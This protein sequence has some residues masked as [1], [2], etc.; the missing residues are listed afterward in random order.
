MAKLD[1]LKSS[2]FWGF[3]PVRNFLMPIFCFFSVEAGG[4]AGLASTGHKG[5][6]PVM[7]VDVFCHVPQYGG[8]LFSSNWKSFAFSLFPSLRKW[9]RFRASMALKGIKVIEMSGLAPAP[10]C[11]MILADFGASVIRIDRARALMDV[12]RLGRGKRSI[13]LNLK[14]PQGRAV[15]HQ[16]CRRADVLIDP[17]RRGVMEKLGLGP[18]VLL[19]EN[20]KL[21]YA[22]LTGFGQNGPLADRAGHDI[23][24]LA[25]SGVLSML[26]RSNESPLPPVN[27]L[28]D[29]AGGGLICALGIVMALFHRTRSNQGQVIDTSMVEGAAYVSSWLYKSQDLFVW[30][31]PRG[32]NAL[33]GGAYFYQTYE[34]KDSKY[35]AVGALEP[36]FFHEF[37][38]KLGLSPSEFEH[39]SKWEENKEHIA[40]I[41]R[42]KTQEEWEKIFHESDACVTP[43][44]EMKEAPQH[45]HN[46][47]RESFFA[48]EKGELEPSPAPH[49]S[50]VPSQ[51]ATHS[52]VIGENSREIL[53]ELGFGESWI[54]EVMQN[55]KL[56][57][58]ALRKTV[59]EKLRQLS[60]EERARQSLVVTTMLL[61]TDAY[62]NAQRVSLY[63]S[64]EDEID[65]RPIVEDVFAQKKSCFIP[66]Y[67]KGSP[68]MDMVELYSL[69]D[70]ESLPLNS[71]GIK[72]PPLEDSRPNALESGGLDLVLVPGL[73]FTRD[74]LRLG[75]GRGYYDR[76]LTDCFQ[77]PC[78]PST[79]ALAFKEQIFEVVPVEESDFHISHVLF[80][81]LQ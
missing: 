6:R 25:L 69:K 78:K 31:K 46:V 20:P 18:Q 40:A 73:A 61:N 64:M 54:P 71:W 37:I 7:A 57:K 26:G 70:L 3:F 14:M 8:R 42:T 79:I 48:N 35:M 81:G 55:I 22:R 15:A 39:F 33:D 49:L 13:A 34:T 53:A 17:Y 45:P 12:D 76:F 44:L 58:S 5:R 77:L 2:D 65:T 68:R 16:L 27:L 41:F 38:S 66:R 50:E 23:N 47:A 19:S 62:K 60:I 1:S 11:G 4:M 29:F 59:K 32:Q 21:I 67:E 72:Q 80:E 51:K 10:F 30:G 28:A 56:L 75:R 36:Q 74:G 43:V 24:Y 52:P 9:R 63:L